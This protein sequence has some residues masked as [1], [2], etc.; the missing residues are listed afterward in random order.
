MVIVWLVKSTEK[1]SIDKIFSFLFA[2]LQYGFLMVGVIILTA[3][4][5]LI[6]QPKIFIS[7]QKRNSSPGA[8]NDPLHVAIRFLS[9]SPI[10]CKQRKKNG[11]I[12]DYEQ[13]F[14]SRISN[15]CGTWQPSKGVVVGE[16]G[17]R[18]KERGYPIPFSSIFLPATQT[19]GTV[20]LGEQLTC[21]APSLNESKWVQKI[22]AAPCVWN[23]PPRM[24][25]ITHSHFLL[26]FYFCVFCFVSCFYLLIYFHLTCFILFQLFAAAFPLAPLIAL[27]TNAIDMKIDASR[28]LWI[29][30][31][32][33]AFRAEDIGQ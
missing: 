4:T 13:F 19:I 18:E 6:K 17:A 24:R 22:L 31:R 14:P 29:D 10:I 27:L 26:H 33:V 23:P 28:L 21:D 9:N 30:R 8:K 5:N 32:P 12:I 20:E 3:T 15:L 1:S 7:S 2:V 16:V 11:D 25:E